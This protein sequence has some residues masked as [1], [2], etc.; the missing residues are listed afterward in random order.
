MAGKLVLIVIDGLTA[1][2]FERGIE[3]GRLPT[4][5]RLAELGRYT[6][7]VSAFPSVTPVCLTTI[8]TGAAQDVH[9]IPHLSWYSRSERRFVEYGSSLAAMRA[10]GFREALR[11]ASVEMSRS[12]LSSSAVTVFEALEDAGLVT[13]AINF[14]CYRGRQEHRIKLPGVARRNRWYET[15]LA[16]SRFFFFNA[17]ESDRTGAP[18][19]VR[20]RSAG[21]VDA[22]AAAVG[23][24]LVTRD[25]FDFLVYYLPDYDFASHVSGPDAS[26]AA[27]ERSDACVARLIEAAGGV[28]EFLE[29]YAL[30]VCADHGQT[31]VSRIARV[32]E[33][34]RD[35]RLLSPRRALAER[36][37]IAVT[38][39]NRAAMVY[40]LAGGKLD[41]RRLAERLDA[42]P[43]ADVVL[44][45]E[46][47]EA[48]ARREREELRF[49]PDGS[50]F[51]L[52][53]D[54]DVLDA[55]RY[56]DGLERVWRALSC[57]RAGD[58]IVSAA[59]GWEFADLG[60]RHHAGGGS[61][62][63][64]LAEDSVVPI[65]SIGISSPGLEERPSIRD[66][67]P[68]ALGSFGIEPP[69]S[70]RRRVA[71]HA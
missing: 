8:A 71:L 69:L 47:G 30:V 52:V 19:A 32:E 29:R 17:Y 49:A 41:T 36:A 61:H 20:S 21:S 13:G 63:S 51:R 18:I 48:V 6:R 4:L 55:E 9:G 27:L 5:G 67:A 22:Y 62:G 54:R 25:G 35:L 28:D 15:V 39:S 56:P 14:T 33:A 65:L 31:S 42:T 12:H 60:G 64:L 46:D 34:F 11:D 66:L 10:S 3:S 24:W 40:R 38:A 37:D 43:G 7:A 53:G 50:G 2:A 16:P 45:L 68:L 26:S 58:V 1:S 23:R 70:M 59:D 44:F 57:D